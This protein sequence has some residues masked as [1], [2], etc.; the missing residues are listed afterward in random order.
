[1]ALLS[2]ASVFTGDYTGSSCGAPRMS[3]PNMDYVIIMM[4]VRIGVGTPSPIVLYC[5]LD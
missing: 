1:M 5:G 4:D 2:D 3:P